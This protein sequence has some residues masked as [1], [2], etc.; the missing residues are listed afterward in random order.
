MPMKRPQINKTVPHVL[1]LQKGDVVALSL[2]DGR[3]AYARVFRGAVIG[4]FRLLSCRLL[5]LER[6][7]GYS[8]AFCV[9]FFCM[10]KQKPDMDW[11]FLGQM[12][13]AA[14]EA[15]WPPPAFSEDAASPGHFHIHYM[16]KISSVTKAQTEG[17]HRAIMSSPGSIRKRILQQCRDWPVI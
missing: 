10:P 8:M 7:T 3:W 2:R 16:G 13:F 5:P 1:S 4:V 17:L 15:E 9:G 12:P 11:I 14:G 6:L